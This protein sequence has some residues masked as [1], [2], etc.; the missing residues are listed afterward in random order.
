MA[1]LVPVPFVTTVLAPMWI[2]CAVF[3]FF[4]IG[5]AF[6][7]SD[8]YSRWGQVKKAKSFDEEK[9]V[10]TQPLPSPYFIQLEAEISAGRKDTALETWH[11]AKASAPASLELLKEVVQMF[12]KAKPD[13]L[14]E[15]LIAHITSHR[16]MLGNA[17]TAAAVLEVVSRSGNLELLD[18][19]A[20]ELKDRFQITLSF[21]T[22]EVLLG[23][24]AA[25]GDENK[26]SELF[27]EICAIGQK[28]TA[29]AYAFVIKGFLKNGLLDAAVPQFLAMREQGFFVPSFAVAH[30]FRLACQ[31]DRAVEIFEKVVE[32]L[33]LP[34]E[35]FVVLLEHA[36]KRN[37][38]PFALSLEKNA[39]KSKTQLSLNAYDFILKTCVAQGSS[40]AFEVLKNMQESAIQM[41][42][43]FYV[44]L[45]AR[46]AD[47][48]FL[49]FAEAVAS[50]ARENAG[51]SLAVYSAFMKCYAYCGMYDKAC[52]LYPEIRAAGLEPDS[53]MCG[54]LM[55]FAVECG[56]TDLSQAL[57]NK[58][59]TLDIQ[60]YMS[61]I[62]AAGKDKDVDR[63]FTILAKLKESFASVDIAAYNSVLDVCASAGDM[64]RARGLFG[65]MEKITKLDI[66]TYNTLL[67]GYCGLGDLRAAKDVLATMKKAGLSPD[68]VSYNC[69]INAAVSNGNFKE[70]W[71]SVDMMESNGVKADHY[72][73]STMM[74]A[75]RKGKDPR[76]VN[77]A[78]ELLDRSGVNVCSDEILFNVVLDTCV[79]HRHMRRLESTVTAFTKSNLRP[80]VHTYG[81]LV[82]ACSTLKW[83][84]QCRDLWSTMVDQYAMEPNEVVLGCMLDALVSSGDVEDAVSLMKEWKDKFPPN[85]VMFSTII[86]GFATTRQASRARDMWKEM[87]E[88]GVPFNVVVYNALI[89][90]QARIGAMDE[91]SKLVES[92][93][94]HGC[95]PDNITYNTIVKGYC[96]KGDIDKAFE[97][98]RNMQNNGL[99]VDAVVYN[100]IMDGCTKES[101]W[102][103]V[104]LA[105]GSMEQNGITPSNFTLGILVKMYGRRKQ[106]DKAFQVIE[107]LSQRHGLRVNMQV[108]TCLMSAC[109]NNNEIERALA[110]FWDIKAVERSVDA[111]AYGS[112]IS[113]CVRQGQC[114]R[115][116]ELVEDAYGIGHAARR[117]LTAGQSLP[118]E[119]M[120]QL[121]RALGQRQLMRTMGAPLLEKM[122]VARVPLSGKFLAASMQG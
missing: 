107:E 84:E 24:H 117:G 39:M 55:K 110:V 9:E 70:A 79:R 59:P 66:I 85:T 76:D 122:R 33:P 89:D 116:V 14:V 109:I 56:R 26:V 82:K 44:G 86:K 57:F 103:L 35:A 4:A 120:E 65:E 46:C 118:P 72:T 36:L 69:L 1:A 113:G 54:C 63:A 23:A 73:I 15:E 61:L 13:E 49:R 3:L 92:M 29:R 64:K 101:R 47:S 16:H 18:K 102:D 52:D 98:F 11:I 40:H 119:P 87:D 45:L 60:N 41:S 2:E 74:K 12:L 37:D 31:L 91:V 95:T 83:F 25:V 22:Y 75:A 8:L 100:V 51:M 111:N 53:V 81:S 121:M 112:L 80:S 17:K 10:E 93:E 38:L 30:L 62:K 42:E 108:K 68:D 21:L 43:G 5:F 105:L 96:V 32:T 94:P 20:Q 90:A 106:L 48:K 99:A 50:V 7:R 78:M 77:R 88:L 97:I 58:A 67:K 19:L 104:D 114:E 115:A 27:K 71:N 6:I 34:Q 28:P